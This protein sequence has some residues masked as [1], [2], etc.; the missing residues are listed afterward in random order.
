MDDRVLAMCELSND[1]LFHKIPEDKVSLYVD[2]P[3]KAGKT[4]AEEL[5]GQDIEALYKQYDIEIIRHNEKGKTFGVVLR[6]QATMSKQGCSVEVYEKSIKEL[7]FEEDLDF[8]TARNIHLAHE[9]FHFL[10]YKKGKTVSEEMPP[11]ETLK[12]LGFSRK[13]LINR[14]SEIAA[15]S[16]AK[17]FLDLEFLPNYY[18]YCYLIKTKKLTEVQWE[19]TLNQMKKLL[20]K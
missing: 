8:D 9:F 2:I 18:D 10:E 17:N 5:K 16:F 15:H 3:L 11:V 19:E 7:A 6:G 13:A 20:D 4:A 14:C 1:L 12:V